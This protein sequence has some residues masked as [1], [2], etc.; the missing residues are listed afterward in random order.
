MSNRPPSG[1]TQPTSSGS[2]LERAVLAL[3][4]QRPQEA[5]RLAAGVL[6]SNRGNLLAARVLGRA[7]LMQNRAVEAII[8]LE[9]AARRADD[10]AIETE[11]AIALAAAGRRDEALDQLRQTTA[12]RPPFP[13]AFVEHGGLLAKIGRLEEATAVLESGLALAPEIVELQIELGFVYLKRNDRAKARS[14][15]SKVLE[16]SPERTDVLPALARVMAFDGEYVAAADLFRRALG[17]RPDDVMTRNNLGA[18]LLEMGEREAGEASLRAAV[19]NAPQ[20]AGLAI[21]SLA[22]ASHGRFFLRPSAAAKFLR[23]EKT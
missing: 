12:R 10:P 20:M 16:R 8:P 11:L 22:A 9:R 4:M 2:P 15:F 21:T 6:K 17:L 13:Q 18:C 5:E 3:R 7:L 1:S 19:R 14:M 23:G